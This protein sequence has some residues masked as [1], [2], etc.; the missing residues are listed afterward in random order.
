MLRTVFFS[1]SECDRK[2]VT[3][4][5]SAKLFERN[6]SVQGLMERRNIEDEVAIDATIRRAIQNS[7]RTIVFVG[8]HTSNSFWVPREVQLTLNSG[9]CVYAMRLQGTRG[10]VPNC[11][12]EA[13]IT[14]HRWSENRLH[15]LATRWI[16]V[17]STVMHGD[18]SDSS[19]GPRQVTKGGTALDES[20]VA[21]QRLLSSSHVSRDL[22]RLHD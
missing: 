1:F 15:D 17:A 19:S 14:V 5:L 7:S 9:N 6:F 16:R 8:D 18:G 12:E 3:R 21:M 22:R 4:I 10:A 11:L 20:R 13:N 2:V